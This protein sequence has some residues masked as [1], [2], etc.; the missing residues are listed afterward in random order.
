M[1]YLLALIGRLHRW[2]LRRFT[3]PFLSLVVLLLVAVSGVAAGEELV[4]KDENEYR[5]LMW[6]I[7]QYGRDPKA[8][9]NRLATRGT[10]PTQVASMPPVTSPAQSMPRRLPPLAQPAASSQ[11][12]PVRYQPPNAGDDSQVTKTT[13][14]GPA[15]PVLDPNQPGNLNKDLDPSNNDADP[16]EMRTPVLDPNQA[17]I[18]IAAWAP[19]NDGCKPREAQRGTNFL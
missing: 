15:A 17:G 4:G 3:S 1:L 11:M 10:V 2:V 7:D 14:D 5:V 8:P 9:Q 19:W 18:W 12:M 13:E 16:N 6:Q